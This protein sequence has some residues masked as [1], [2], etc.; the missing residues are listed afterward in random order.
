MT[1]NLK[2]VY[3]TSCLSKTNIVRVS[4]WSNCAG[5]RKCARL[6]RMCTYSVHIFIP[7]L[8]TPTPIPRE[9]MCSRKVGLFLDPGEPILTNCNLISLAS[10]W[11][12]EV[13]ACLPVLVNETWGAGYWRTSGTRSPSR[14]RRNSPSSHWT[15]CYALTLCLNFNTLQ[16]LWQG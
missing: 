10:D 4:C 6:D 11:F 16:P 15:S 12:K 7:L 2:C 1:E 9:A 13:H 5:S 3:S 14:Q 8:P